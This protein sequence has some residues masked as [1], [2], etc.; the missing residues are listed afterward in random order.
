M[1]SFGLTMDAADWPALVDVLE[2]PYDGVSLCDLLYNGDAGA[3][4]LA[5]L[6]DRNV[7]W[8]ADG[9]LAAYLEERACPAST[10]AVDRVWSITDSTDGVE[11]ALQASVNSRDPGR[12][13]IND[14]AFSLDGAETEIEQFRYLTTY[15]G[16]REV[17][18]AL[19]F[20][21][22]FAGTMIERYN[23]SGGMNVFAGAYTEDTDLV[24]AAIAANG[25]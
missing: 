19:G 1:V 9:D 13:L 22:G 11:A 12:L 6:G 3:A 25:G 21:G 14:F 16:V 18:E 10:G 4:T 24:A 17:S 8:A 20:S 5:D 2:A 7:V 23:A 15:P